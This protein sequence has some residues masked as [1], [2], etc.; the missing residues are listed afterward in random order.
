MP[1]KNGGGV[2][3]DVAVF[4]HGADT[5]TFDWRISIAEVDAAG[6]FSRF[7]G[8]D[9]ILTVLDGRLE[10]HF[11][12]GGD[13][14]GLGPGETFAFPGDVAVDGRPLGGPVRD[15]NVMVRRGLWRADVRPWNAQL[16]VVATRIAIATS[17]SASASACIDKLDALILDQQESPP[18]GF[19][20]LIVSLEL[21][22][23]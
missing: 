18:R 2:T 23:S 8:I 13:A 10:L 14:I 9:R 19:I 7:D 12:E 17:A 3:R 22:G 6:P 11:A 20:G 15:L 16:P 4:P 21:I 5:T 1:W